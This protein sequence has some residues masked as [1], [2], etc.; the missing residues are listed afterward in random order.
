MKAL[1][2]IVW[3]I[4]LLFYLMPLWALLGTI[5]TLLKYRIWYKQTHIA[6]EILSRHITK[7]MDDNN[8]K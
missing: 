5:D 1:K 8:L 4:L 6:G 2:E 3:E 7:V